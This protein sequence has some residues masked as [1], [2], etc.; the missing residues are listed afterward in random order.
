MTRIIDV[1]SHRYRGEPVYVS[2]N[3]LM[4]YVEGDPRRC[5]AP[6]AFVVKETTTLWRNIY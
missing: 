5:V 3:M 1:L 6:D 4:Y 2:G